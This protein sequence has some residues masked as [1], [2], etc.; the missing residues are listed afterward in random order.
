M[1][2]RQQTWQRIEFDL[3]VVLLL[4]FGAA[5]TSSWRGLTSKKRLSLHGDDA[6]LIAFGPRLPQVI[7]SDFEGKFEST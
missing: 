4:A 5:A 6:V 2:R 7:T 3:G 1:D